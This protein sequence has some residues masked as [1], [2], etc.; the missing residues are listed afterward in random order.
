VVTVERIDTLARTAADLLRELGV[1][2]VEVVVGDGTV[3]HPARGPYDRVI[4]TAAAPQVP[5]SLLKQLADPG[6]LVCPVGDLHMQFL[7]VVRRSGGRD[8]VTRQC[9]CRFVPLLGA[10]G[11]AP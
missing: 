11:F 5:D 8:V 4:V 3:G 6:V 2:N 10:E 9:A 1:E 7:H